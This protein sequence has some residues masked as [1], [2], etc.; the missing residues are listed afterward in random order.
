MAEAGDQFK[1]ASNSSDGIPLTGF[2]DLAP[3]S[4][5]GTKTR[6]EH[7]NA[8]RVAVDEAATRSAESMLALR[9]AVVA[10]TTDLRDTG[11]TP[12]A[13]LISLKKVVRQRTDFAG[14]M[15][16]EKISSWCIEEFFKEK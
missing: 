10:F 1:R 11:M 8:L 15:M 7:S 5:A 6:A 3:A 4:R 16:R 2:G 9:I 13:V 12:E 14:I